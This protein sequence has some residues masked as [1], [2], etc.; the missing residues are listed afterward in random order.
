MGM[1]EALYYHEGKQGKCYPANEPERQ[2]QKVKSHG[3]VISRHAGQYIEAHRCHVSCLHEIALYPYGPYMIYEHEYDR[4]KLQIRRAEAFF[5]R[6]LQPWDY[7]AGALITKESGGT[8]ETLSGE[9]LSFTHA[10][11]VLLGNGAVVKKI[12]ELLLKG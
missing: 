9:P 5:E 10:E 11:D 6:R 2:I 3:K 12:R 1:Q 4:K 8:A 7:A